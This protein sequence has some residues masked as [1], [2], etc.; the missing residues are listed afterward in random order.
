M[1]ISSNTAEAAS[2]KTVFKRAYGRLDI[3]SAVL[4]CLLAGVIFSLPPQV[5]G[6][7]YLG[8]FVWK[9][10]SIG[11]WDRPRGQNMLDSG[12]PFYDTYQTSDGKYM[13]VGAI[14]PQFYRLLLKGV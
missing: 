14:E 1:D 2:K 6:A 9:S 5:E 13:A 12:A 10:G 8:S 3:N 11:L 7:A 4:G